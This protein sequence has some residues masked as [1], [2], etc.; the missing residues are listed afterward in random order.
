MI[1]RKDTVYSNKICVSRA[2][3]L[4]I[5][6]AF[7]PNDDNLNDSFLIFIDENS[8]LSYQ[9]SVYDDF[10]KLLFVSDDPSNSWDGSFNGEIVQTGS[11]LYQ[12]SLNYA[13]NVIYEDI[14]TVLL[15][16]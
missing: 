3:R 12:V 7:T 2:P 11:Y 13:D 1:S 10:G 9:L 5:P 8:I 4:L 16:H 6:T 14:G 15:L